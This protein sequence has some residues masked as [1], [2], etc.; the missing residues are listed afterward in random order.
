MSEIVIHGKS[1]TIDVSNLNA[2]RFERQELLRSR[3][4]MQVLA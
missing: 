3:Y 4:G 1:K 2:H